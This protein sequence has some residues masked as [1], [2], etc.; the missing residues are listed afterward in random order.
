MDLSAHSS[1]FTFLMFLVAPVAYPAALVAS[2]ADMV[3]MA[4]SNVAE[5]QTYGDVGSAEYRE[6]WESA[7]LKELQGLEESGTATLAQA[8]KWQKH[9][10]AERFDVH[11]LRYYLH[12]R[13]VRENVGLS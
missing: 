1:V 3:G 6:V 7:V 4:I 10:G 11:H 12:K 5:R 9:V 2:L 13:L 8:P